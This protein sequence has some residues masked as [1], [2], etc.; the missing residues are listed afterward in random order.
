MKKVILLMVIGIMLSISLLVG[1]SYALWSNTHVQEGQGIVES[2][3]FS[4]DFS[5]VNSISLSNSYPISD[6]KGMSATPY[7][8]TITNTCSIDAKYEVNFEVLANSTLSSNYVK[9]AIDNEKDILS[10]YESKTSTIKGALSSNNIASGW[11]KADESITYDLRLWMDEATTLDQGEGKVLNGKVVVVS[12]G[13]EAPSLIATLLEQYHVN[14]E[15][16]LVKD[17][18][19]PNLY[20]YTGTNEEVSNNFLW[21][22]GHQWRVVEFDTS[23]NT[24]TLITQ[25]PLT[26]IHPAGEVWIT[27][28]KYNSSYVNKWLSDFFLNTL[29]SNVQTNIVDSAFNIGIYSDVD[30]ITTLKK[31][32][33]LDNDQY[34]RAGQVD[35]FLDIK[36]WWYLGNYF[37]ETRLRRVNDLGYLSYGEVNVAIGIRPVIKIQNLDP[38]IGTGTLTDPYK[39]VDV[40]LLNKDFQIGDYIN[41]KYKGDDN[42]CGTDNI[43][44]FRII[45]K[46]DNDFKMVL[47]GLIN[48]TSSFGGVPPIATSYSIYNVLENFATGFDTNILSQ[49]SHYFNVGNYPAPSDFTDLSKTTILLNYGLP[50][51]GELFSGNDIDLGDSKTFVNIDFIENATIAKGYWLINGYNSQNVRIIN[52]VGQVNYQMHNSNLGVRPVIFIKNNVNILSGDGSPQ[53][54][55]FL[56]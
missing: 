16:G 21:Y 31:V 51:V 20:Y 13:E 26:S 27:E 7:Q 44:T 35:S 12:V 39:Q 22:G 41:L 25:Q 32:G 4:T 10:N 50:T 56:G 43:C 37:D 42:A 8:F 54:P 5:E 17:T 40:S 49:E 11:L 28:E 29:E 36:D 34:F 30:A 55:Y 6:S 1:V 9:L 14:N 23:A 45:E 2:G 38:I 47:N 18:I 24:I 19:N 48:S 46:N 33:L 3:C 52:S 53:A 15:K